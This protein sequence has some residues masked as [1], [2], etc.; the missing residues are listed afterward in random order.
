MEHRDDAGPDG[1]DHDARIPV[2]PKE[3]AVVRDASEEADQDRSEVRQDGDIRDPIAQPC[4]RDVVENCSRTLLSVRF[5]QDIDSEAGTIVGI[6]PAGESIDGE[7]HGPA[8]ELNAMGALFQG[9]SSITFNGAD[10]ELGP[11]HWAVSLSFQVETGPGEGETQVLVNKQASGPNLNRDTYMV[12][13][14][15]GTFEGG[16]L[17]AGPGRVLFCKYEAQ[18]VN[19]G[20]GTNHFVALPLQADRPVDGTCFFEGS[21]LALE[22]ANDRMELETNE[23][24]QVGPGS[25]EICDVVHI[26]NHAPAPC[27]GIRMSSLSVK[28]LVISEKRE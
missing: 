27:R 26:S 24:A 22:T 5:A 11:A 1:G 18:G 2:E 25:L 21:K 6:G 10:H 19:D 23:T 13:I 8:P 20:D 16:R 28:E 4:S 3:D 17:T 7:I 14:Y 12:G 15:G 9:Q